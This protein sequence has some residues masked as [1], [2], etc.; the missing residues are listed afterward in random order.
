MTDVHSLSGAFVLDAL[1]DRERSSFS[2]H[3]E[4]CEACAL[5]VNELRET[6]SRLADDVWSVPPPRMREAVLARVAVTRQEPPLRRSRAPR[7]HRQSWRHRTTMALVA[8][9]MVGLAALSGVFIVQKQQGDSER[10]NIQAV[11]SAPDATFR[12]A[13]LSN[14]GHVSVVMSP[15]RDAAVV[16]LAQAQTFDSDHAYQLWALRGGKPAS[17][18]VMPAGKGDALLY[19][20]GLSGAQTMALT[21]EPAGGS[22]EPTTPI[23]G[24]VR[25]DA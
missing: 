2:R 21:V 5:E 23:V 22:R 3:M 8:A 25:L 19:V 4:S 6:A 10:D 20:T 9:S 13:Q 18:G 11:L 17:A 16:T 14:G 15:S 1:D 12:T 7:A 24:Q